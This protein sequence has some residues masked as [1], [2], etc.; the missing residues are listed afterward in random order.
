MS[1]QSSFPKSLPAGFRITSATVVSR[2][3]GVP[4][5]DLNGETILFHA[6]TGGYYAFDTV[7][8]TIWGMLE[9]PQE[10]AQLC[11]HLSRA[12]LV[13]STACEGDVIPFLEGLVDEGL[14]CIHPRKVTA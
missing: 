2:S 5:T 12:F 1:K 14:L 3:I 11:R 8:S 7:A 6:E 13:E 9:A 10:V 4:F